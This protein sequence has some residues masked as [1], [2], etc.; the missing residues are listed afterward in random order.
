MTAKPRSQTEADQRGRALL[1][2]VATLLAADRA[3]RETFATLCELL[4]RLVDVSV[5]FIALRNGL[6]ELERCAG[7]QFDRRFVASFCAFCRA[8]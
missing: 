8:R 1:A 5:F 2:E 7:S 6:A 4:T 3:P